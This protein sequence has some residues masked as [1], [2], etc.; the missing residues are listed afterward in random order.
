MVQKNEFILTGLSCSHCASVIEDKVN[1][2]DWVKE[3]RVNL[4]TQILYLDGAG[5]K[6][7]NRL[8]LQNL[9]DSIE[10]G[11]LVEGRKGIAAP[12]SLHHPG[13]ALLK[14]I[15]EILGA[16]LFFVLVFIRGKVSLG[17]I[18]GIALYGTSY[19]LIGRSVLYSGLKNMKNGRFL[20]ENF[21]MILAT[22]V[23]FAIQEF[24]EAVA[25]MLFYQLGEFFQDLA[26]DRSRR[27]IRSLMDSK[28]GLVQVIAGTL[29]VETA[30]DLVKPGTLYRLRPGDRIPLDGVVIKG[31]GSVDT[32][33]LTGE[34]YPRQVTEGSP[35]L[36]GYVNRDALLEVKS[37]KSL[38]ESSYARIIRMVEESSSRKARSEQFIT[39]FARYYTPVVVG[40]AALL[41]VVP[42]MLFEGANFRDWLYRAL[43]FLVVSCPC[44]LVISIPLGFFAGIGRASK[45]GILV[46]GGNFLEALNSIDTVFLDKTGTLTKGVFS[47]T[48]LHPAPGVDDQTLLRLAV[49]AESG[50][51]H[52]IAES[53]LRA[54]KERGGSALYPDSV[55]ELAGQ[56]IRARSGDQIISIGKRDW[57]EKS[58]VNLLS[59]DFQEASSEMRSGGTRIAVALDTIYQGTILLSDEIR[60]DTV[61]A[62]KDLRKFGI[63]S[64]IM[65]TG[66]NAATAESV[67]SKLDLDGFY[68]N[69]LPHQKVEAVEKSIASG[70]KTAFMGDGINDAPVLARADVGIAMGGLG[71]DA[72]IEAADIV[73]MADE[74]ARLVNAFKIARKTRRVVMQNII[75]A[76]GIKTVILI[77]AALGYAGMGLA[78]FGDVGVALLAILNVLRIMSGRES[79]SLR[80]PGIVLS[81][82]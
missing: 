8:E 64:I 54:W 5:L 33:A 59:S 3:A 39:R 21:L 40:L 25:V 46:K 79:T 81:G 48:S 27:S 80:E 16:L 1:E 6:E 76:L 29:I 31:Q 74:P 28:P 22:A 19:L 35:V 42:P 18:P 44:A 47:L 62:L 12:P 41:A 66:D 15:P 20:D 36:S 68:A 65:L 10:D 72:A 58:G 43:V 32:S 34:S 38:S 67:A 57:L 50:S 37:T 71:S 63:K 69:L 11:I 77:L 61:Q 70:A 45:E 9:V 30:P 7:E 82:T 49:L 4:A 14:K 60:P 52:P 2:L 13:A 24:P 17:L 23:A 53:L 51:T 78:I 75:L 26:V 73:L 56:G 55:E